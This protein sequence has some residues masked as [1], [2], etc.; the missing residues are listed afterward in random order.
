MR[1]KP[2]QCIIHKGHKINKKEISILALLSWLL[3]DVKG[4]LF[5]IPM[6]SMDD[7]ASRKIKT[8]LS[9]GDQRPL[10]TSK[11]RGVYTSPLSSLFLRRS[12]WA[13]STAVLAT[14]ACSI[15]F[16]NTASVKC[17]HSLYSPRIRKQVEIEVEAMDTFLIHWIPAH[18]LEAPIS[19]TCFD[20]H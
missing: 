11:N 6:I 3:L 7:T 10:T 1:L 16:S 4:H 17:C 20:R 5:W 9:L 2:V 14:V 15:S 18:L 13:S 12:L 19:G 8:D